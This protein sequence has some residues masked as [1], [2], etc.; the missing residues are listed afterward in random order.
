MRSPEVDEVAEGDAIDEV[1]VAMVDIESGIDMVSGEEAVGMGLS[2]AAMLEAEFWVLLLVFEEEEIGDE[3]AGD[4][5]DDMKDDGESEDERD[6]ATEFDE[7]VDRL[8]EV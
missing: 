6:K 7:S 2:S 8:G 4:V 3:E 5:E 1:V